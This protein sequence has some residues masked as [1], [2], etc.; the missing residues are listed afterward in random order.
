MHRTIRRSAPFAAMALA[1]TLTAAVLSIAAPAQAAT[2]DDTV[3]RLKQKVT[4]RI[5]LRL[6]ALERGEA[7]LDRKKHVTDAHRDVLQ[8]LV[9]ADVAGLTA[10]KAKVAG[11]TTAEALK[12]DA[13]S[14]INDY[15]IFILVMPKLRLTAVADNEAAATDR[16]QAAHDKLADLIAKAKAAGKDTAG[17]ERAL[18]A[19]QGSIDDAEDGLAGQV[20]ALLAL[21]P[22]PDGTAIREAVA[23][24]RSALRAVRS[25][26]RDAVAAA[27]KARD[28]I[29]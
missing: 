10:L 8:D 12:A 25:E 2:A 28:L 21:K 23:K 1:A 27:K 20:D 17:A 18:A 16:L 29:K 6:R 22:G 19:M 3:A 13:T 24:I 11:E 5:D 7:R 14:M 4:E 9:D 15:R 26:L